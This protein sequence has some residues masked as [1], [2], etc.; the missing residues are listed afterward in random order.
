M[1][2]D[3]AVSEKKTFKT[4]TILYMYITQGKGQITQ[5]FDCN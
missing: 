3:Q 1:K 4:Y 2:I 5:K